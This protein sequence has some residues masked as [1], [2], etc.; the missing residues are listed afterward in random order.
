MKSLHQVYKVGG[1]FLILANLSCETES[2][3]NSPPEFDKSESEWLTY[4]SEIGYDVSELNNHV[5]LISHVIGCASCMREIEWWNIEGLDE[6]DVNISIILIER[7]EATF[8][9]FVETRGLSIPVYWD[10][11]GLVLETELV[12]STPVKLYFDDS[13]NISEVQTLGGGDLKAFLNSIE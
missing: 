3:D 13:G 4:F 5:L 6:V 11:T 7:H 9:N 2:S 1:V 12:Q 8:N 10:K